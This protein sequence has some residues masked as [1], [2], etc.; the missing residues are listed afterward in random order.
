MINDLKHYFFHRRRGTD[1]N[2]IPTGLRD[3][4]KRRAEAF[5]GPRFNHLYRRWLVNEDVAFKPVP[6]V[7]Q[8]ALAC[9]RARI[10]CVVLPNTYEHLSP[11]VSR[12]RARRRRGHTS[13]E[14]GE[15]TPHGINPFLNPVPYP[16]AA[17]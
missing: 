13:E 10:E 15:Q 17:T 5:A 7:I 3:L 4:L 12:R 11:L 8:Q 16:V 2:A 9:G 1:L 14:K 6:A